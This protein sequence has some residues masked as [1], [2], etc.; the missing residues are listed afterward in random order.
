M[1]MEALGADAGAADEE[2]FVEAPAPHGRNTPYMR[3]L[4]LYLFL[5][6]YYYIWLS[7]FCS[8]GSCSVSA[9]LSLKG[10]VSFEF[11]FVFRVLMGFMCRRACRNYCTGCRCPCGDS[12]HPLTRSCHDAYPCCHRFPLTEARSYRSDD[13]YCIYF[14][15]C[16]KVQEHLGTFYLEYYLSVLQLSA[17]SVECSVCRRL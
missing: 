2:D 12:V 15:V 8:A 13:Y 7:K 14:L 16:T 6:F 3:T 4:L 17:K 11:A 10:E 1:E 5:L 9:M